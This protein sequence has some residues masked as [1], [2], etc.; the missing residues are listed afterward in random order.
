MLVP[1]DIVGLPSTHILSGLVSDTNVILYEAEMDQGQGYRGL[2]PLL[3][4]ITIISLP[5]AAIYVLV[6]SL[7][8]NYGINC[9][10]SC[11]WVRKEYS[12][13][14]WYRVYSNRIETNKPVCRLFG[15]CGCG[16]WNGD[17]IL[18][19]PFDRGAFGF[20]RVPAGVVAYLC[21]VWPLY[22]WT[23]AR[24]RCQCNGPLWHGGWW[25][26]EWICDMCFC[27]YRYDGMANGD[28]VA[29][30]S[31]IVLQAY[32]EGRKIT[33]EDVDKCIEYWRNNISEQSDPEGRKR[34]VMCEPHY[35]PCPTMK[36]FYKCCHFKRTVPYGDE[37]E[38]S[39]KETRAVSD[40][41]CIVCLFL[42]YAFCG[43][44]SNSF[45]C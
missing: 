11:Q 28:E 38:R 30:V 6:K 23:V 13:R 10:E 35:V 1:D 44:R 22:G 26:D 4:I 9:D 20:R 33:K 17:A 24:Q 7:I 34:K 37:D 3:C 21:C 36:L 5:F 29:I 19:H 41:S 32:F 18:T 8:S 45:R 12:T 16:S 39:T 40:T 2:R 42:N 27:S 25:C 15:M 43:A 31:S 14:T